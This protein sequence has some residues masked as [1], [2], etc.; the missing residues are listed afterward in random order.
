M[1]GQLPEL[2]PITLTIASGGTAG[3]ADL[4]GGILV[5]IQMPAALT[6]TILTLTGS[7]THG[8]TY[9]A[10]KDK[11]PTTIPTITYAASTMFAV[12]PVTFAQVRSLKITSNGAEAADRAFILMV[13]H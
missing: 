8:G 1:P 12:D 11:T 4:K 6:G 13:K 7:S 5:G 9:G 2:E 10:I 3:T